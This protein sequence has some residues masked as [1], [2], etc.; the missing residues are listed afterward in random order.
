MSVKQ[1]AAQ[2]INNER[3]LIAKPSQ[4]RTSN[5][6]GACSSIKGARV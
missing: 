4:R 5:A 2:L 3:Y 6:N 1:W